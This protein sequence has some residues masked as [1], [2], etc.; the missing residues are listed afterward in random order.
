MPNYDKILLKENIP[1]KFINN[2]KPFDFI[3]NFCKEYFTLK[4]KNAKFTFTKYQLETYFYLSDCPLNSNEFNL[5]I[6]YED[7]EVIETNLIG[8]IRDEKSE[9]N[10]NNNNSK[11]EYF[12]NFLK[13]EKENK[14]KGIFTNR[15]LL[16]NYLESIS[17]NKTNIRK[18]KEELEWDIDYEFLKC[19]VDDKNK[20]NVY[21]QNSFSFEIVDEMGLIENL[22][23]CQYNF[24]N[25]DYPIVVIE[26]TN[27]GGYGG[28]SIFFQ[29]IVQNLFN[30]QMKCSIKN[31]RIYIINFR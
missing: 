18:L 19:R 9:N 25:N 23:N 12:Y 28:F 29:E 17:N 16:K 6:V 31:R 27:G 5:T 10:N 24:L 11:Y 13:K 2:E 3:R 22:I 4:N 1:I 26:D 8:F 20:V 15:K 7:E 14:K 21:Y 30:N